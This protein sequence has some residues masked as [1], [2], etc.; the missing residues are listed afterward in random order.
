MASEIELIIIC[1]K[2]GAKYCTMNYSERGVGQ[3]ERVVGA[4]NMSNV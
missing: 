3:R 4:D 2:S 1:L